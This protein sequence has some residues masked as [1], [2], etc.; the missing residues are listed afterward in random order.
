MHPFYLVLVEDPGGGSYLGRGYHPR[1]ENTRHWLDKLTKG[2]QNLST[3]L[4]LED[5]GGHSVV[6]LGHLLDKVQVGLGGRGKKRKGRGKRGKVKGQTVIVF[7]GRHVSQWS[8][9]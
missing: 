8:F 6:E 5:R 4:H 2:A 3:I 9:S 7:S 1:R